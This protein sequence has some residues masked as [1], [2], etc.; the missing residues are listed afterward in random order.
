VPVNFP[1]NGGGSYLNVW[2]LLWTVQAKST[3]SFPLFNSAYEAYNTGELIAF[4][5]G[6]ICAQDANTTVSPHCTA[7]G[8]FVPDR[9][10]TFGLVVNLSM[11]F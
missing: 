5:D 4:S 3:P 6:T 9:W 11:H 1:A 10:Y 2:S 8:L 7:S